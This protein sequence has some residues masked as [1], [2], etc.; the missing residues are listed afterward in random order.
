MHNLPIGCINEE[1]GKDISKTIRVVKM[2]DVD[3]KGSGWGLTLCVL[4]EV[5]LKKSISR[6]RTINV[7][8]NKHW[9]TLTFE[10]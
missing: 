1:M 6:G 9:I 3:K 10:K 2:C 5:D 8:G 4:I 7:M